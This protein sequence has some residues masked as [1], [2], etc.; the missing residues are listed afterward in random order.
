MNH[1]AQSAHLEECRQSRGGWGE[2]IVLLTLISPAPSTGQSPLWAFQWN[3]CYKNEMHNCK[4]E[5][6]ANPQRQGAQEHVRKHWTILPLPPL[7]LRPF[8]FAPLAGGW[9][10][11][12]NLS[13]TSGISET[14]LMTSVMQIVCLLD[15]SFLFSWYLT[16][17][18]FPVW[19][20]WASRYRMYHQ[21]L[22]QRHQDI[23]PK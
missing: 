14:C 10:S 16:P 11:S 8:V 18:L 2:F 13:S 20:A 23:N 17:D 12:F 3:T 7:P 5:M 19:A 4:K 22:K 21:H 9:I 15:T 6:Q 1:L